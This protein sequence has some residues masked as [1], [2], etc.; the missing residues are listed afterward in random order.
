MGFFTALK[1]KSLRWAVNRAGRHAKGF[2]S[3]VKIFNPSFEADVDKINEMIEDLAFKVEKNGQLRISLK[4]HGEETPVRAIID[5]SNAALET[6]PFI[7]LDDIRFSRAWLNILLKNYK[8]ELASALG[9]A[10]SDNKFLLPEEYASQIR[11]IL[12]ETPINN[13]SDNS[14]E[15]AG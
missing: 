7:N 15:P 4:L 1:Q 3:I 2:W 14:S 11:K 12:P 6:G 8:Q 10:L 13:S 9:L 5:L